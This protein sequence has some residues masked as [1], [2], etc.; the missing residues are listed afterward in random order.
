MDELDH[1]VEPRVYDPEAPVNRQFGR[2]R[3]PDQGA[4]SGEGTG[5]MRR[6]P[7]PS[8]AKPEA[9]LMRESSCF[10]TIWKRHPEPICRLFADSQYSGFWDDRTKLYTIFGRVPGRG[11][12][13]I[14]RSSAAKFSDFPQLARVLQSDDA[15]PKEADLYN[16]ACL[17]YPGETDLYLMFPSLF[18]HQEDTL[19]IRLAVSRD[20]ETWTWPDRET[21]LIA[22]GAQGDFDSSSLY[23]G[24]GGCLR[25]G[26]EWSYYFSG[27]S[28]KHREVELEFLADPKRR[29]VIG[30]ADFNYHRAFTI[31]ARF[32]DRHATWLFHDA[33]A[34]RASSFR[35]N[36][37]GRPRS[38][39]SRRQAGFRR[40]LADRTPFPV[41]SRHLI[42]IPV[43]SPG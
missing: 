11:G 20:C 27:S 19:E 23:M 39:H 6:P 22:L 16:P 10:P 29:R 38:D 41:F 33:A 34:S 32:Q 15:D 2:K 18:R 8:K 13:A 40:L 3:I 36:A 17:R 30:R 1:G 26:D 5:K 14:G 28:L 37:A 42:Q 31:A 25:T 7:R 9:P 43:H 21:P 35:P 12:R 24:N 4:V